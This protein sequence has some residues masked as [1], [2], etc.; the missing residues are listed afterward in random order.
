MEFSV[1][2]HLKMSN[3]FVYHTIIRYN[4]RNVLTSSPEMVRKV[5]IAD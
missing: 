5:Q 3:M 4:D 2:K 1:I